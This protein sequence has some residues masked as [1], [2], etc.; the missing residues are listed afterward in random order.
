[1]FQIENSFEVNVT[2]VSI[3]GDICYTGPGLNS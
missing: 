3:G 2:F 1:M